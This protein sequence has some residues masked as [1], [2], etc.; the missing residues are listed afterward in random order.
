MSA[1]K[2]L[3][4]GIILVLAAALVL[5]AAAWYSYTCG[6]HDFGTCPAGQ[7]CQVT[8]QDNCHTVTDYGSCHLCPSTQEQVCTKTCN[9]DYCSGTGGGTCNPSNGYCT[10]SQG[11]PKNYGSEQS[12]HQHGYIWH[13]A[14]TCPYE[15]GDCLSYAIQTVYECHTSGYVSCDGQNHEKQILG[16]HQECQDVYS[17]QAISGY[18][19]CNSQCDG[20][21]VCSGHACVDLNCPAGQHAENHACVPDQSCTS[22]VVGEYT[23]TFTSVSGPV[24]EHTLVIDTYNSGTG[25][26]TG[27]GFYN[28]DG[29]T[30][31]IT[32]TIT[33]TSIT[34]TLTGPG[35]TQ[36]YTL[37]AT[38]EID[39][40]VI[41]GSGS[42]VEGSDSGTWTMVPVEQPPEPP[43]TPPSGDNSCPPM[44]FLDKIFEKPGYGGV[45]G[46][47]AQSCVGVPTEGAIQLDAQDGES[48]YITTVHN[49]FHSLEVIQ[50]FPEGADF[51]CAPDGTRTYYRSGCYVTRVSGTGALTITAKSDQGFTVVDAPSFGTDTQPTTITITNK[52]VDYSGV[53]ADGHV[54]LTFA[55]TPLKGNP[56]GLFGGYSFLQLYGMG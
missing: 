45:F 6:P 1:N 26:F 25:A 19:T 31:L 28:L 11:H 27:H 36:G 51:T 50:H 46:F 16:T 7:G 3:I 15:R 39:G 37:T 10:D 52:D 49:G 12:C 2:I 13:N 43:V 53:A 29:Q 32:G 48:L 21:Q 5:P 30:W 40:C 9:H 41:S 18:C 42:W 23:L 38:G 34:Y 8:G 55:R 22:G 33:G 35:S 47:I 24:Y 4:A 20:D 14:V 54:D 17:C 44:S 56:W